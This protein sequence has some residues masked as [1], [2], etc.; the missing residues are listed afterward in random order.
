MRRLGVGLVPRLRKRA[1]KAIR[2]AR[3]LLI[4]TSSHMLER[5]QND[6]RIVMGHQMKMS[7]R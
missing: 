2:V 4:R 1:S 6:A 5:F 7:V 3:Q